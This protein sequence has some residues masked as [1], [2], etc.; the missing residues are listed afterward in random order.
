MDEDLLR[1]KQN[2]DA[3]VRQAVLNG[4]RALAC[5]VESAAGRIEQEASNTS[6]YRVKPH[7]MY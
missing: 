5:S 6:L 7:V 1:I 3:S 2:Y 4:L